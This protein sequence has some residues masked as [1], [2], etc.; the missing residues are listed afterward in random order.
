MVLGGVWEFGNL[1]L[2]FTVIW[3]SYREREREREKKKKTY[4]MY[5]GYTG[6]L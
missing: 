4:S 3:D 5:R 6:V 2:G 1:R